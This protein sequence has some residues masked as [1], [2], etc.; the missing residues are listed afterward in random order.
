MPALCNVTRDSVT[1][2]PSPDQVFPGWWKRIRKQHLIS[3]QQVL[4]KRQYRTHTQGLLEL[5]CPS[6]LVLFGAS[7]YEVQEEELMAS[8]YP[9]SGSVL[10]IDLDYASFSSLCMSFPAM[11]LIFTICMPNYAYEQ[12]GP[13]EFSHRGQL[14]LLHMHPKLSRVA[15]RSWTC[16]KTHVAA[17]NYCCGDNL[18]YCSKWGVQCSLKKAEVSGCSFLALTLSKS[19]ECLGVPYA[20]CFSTCGSAGGKGLRCACIVSS[21]HQQRRASLCLH[22][23]YQHKS[24]MENS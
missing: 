9:V 6:S 7:F 12:D 23:R 16:F 3:K 2:G 14:A 21:G 11:C 13:W 18:L 8:G 1:H 4:L 24:H 10:L 20:S 15:F 5:E 19:S 22:L 17:G